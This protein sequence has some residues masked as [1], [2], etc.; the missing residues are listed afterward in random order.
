M[1]FH[2]G[3]LTV[4]TFNMRT[5][6]PEHF[7]SMAQTLRLGKFVT[8]QRIH[9][10]AIQEHH[11]YF[12]DAKAV[13]TA[14]ISTYGY[15]M[16]YTSATR[17]IIEDSCVSRGGIGLLIHDSL[18]QRAATFTIVSP[19]ILAAKLQP[20]PGLTI[21]VICVYAPTAPSMPDRTEFFSTLRRYLPT[22]PRQELRIVAGDFNSVLRASSKHPFG[23]SMPLTHDTQPAA[24]QFEAF[25]QQHDLIATS[26][27][28]DLPNKVTFFPPAGSAR[29]PLQLD[30]VLTNAENVGIIRGTRFIT[31]VPLPSDHRPTTTTFDLL[32]QMP[33]P[34]AM[35][36][37]NPPPNLRKLKSDVQA[38]NTFNET[39]ISHMQRI[40]QDCP[41]GPEHL[42]DFHDAINRA[43]A[44]LGTQ[45][46]PRALNAAKD[47]GIQQLNN[48]FDD[49]DPTDTVAQH[50]V[51]R[52]MTQLR[53]QL[54]AA[55]TKAAIDSFARYITNDPAQSYRYLRTIFRGEYC[56][57]AT[58]TAESPQHRLQLI[59][60]T[61]AAQLNNKA[62]NPFIKFDEHKEVDARKYKT[63][64]IT[65][66]ELKKAL[67]LANNNKA[68]GWDQFY[69]EFLK[70]QPVR[71]HALQ[72][73]NHCLHNGTM[74]DELK[75]T[76]FTMIPKPGAEHTKPEGY[77]Y[78]ALMPHLTKLYNIVLRERIV[79]VIDPLLRRNQ[80]GFRA[81][82]STLQ[83]IITLQS[84]MD[85]AR[86]HPEVRGLYLIFIDFKNAFPSVSHASI[87]AALRS[88]K[89]PDKLVDAIMSVYDGH[90]GYVRTPEG[91]TPKFDITAGVLQ[92]DTLAPY[93]FL[94]VLNEVLRKAIPEQADGAEPMFPGCLTTDRPRRSCAKPYKYAFSG[95]SIRDIDYADDI[96]LIELTLEAAQALL[97]AVQREAEQVGLFVNT[98]KTQFVVIKAG[99][100]VTLKKIDEDG[101]ADT[102][103]ARIARVTNYRYL[104]RLLDVNADITARVGAGWRAL[105]KLDR[106]WKA[107]QEV[108]DNNYKRRLFRTFV[109]PTMLYAMCTY[110]LTDAQTRRISGTYTRML[111]RA[112]NADHDAHLTLEQLYGWH[113]GDY[114]LELA[115]VVILRF[116]M[117][118][119]RT[120]LTDN[121]LVGYDVA[122]KFLDSGNHDTFNYTFCLASFMGTTTRTGALETSPWPP[123]A[124]RWSAQNEARWQKRT[125]E[126]AAR[127]HQALVERIKEA[128][129]ESRQRK[130]ERAPAA[131]ARQPQQEQQPARRQTSLFEFGFTSNKHGIL[132]QEQLQQPE[133]S[134]VLDAQLQQLLDAGADDELPAEAESD[135]DSDNEDDFR[136]LPSHADFL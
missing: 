73:F 90:K 10:L 128:S 68:P 83:Q 37:R 21:H 102:H 1:A 61:C 54:L 121:G 109:T 108:A 123:H 115:P 92:G 23:S 8:D 63:G 66:A 33:E 111:R 14:R 85:F 65:E 77:R 103:G 71:E 2:S 3:L 76:V 105:R 119:M 11:I 29:L 70:S 133:P 88:F 5:A 130:R 25:L 31:Q 60:D 81:K 52:Q 39:Y 7:F 112:L 106:I 131:A 110:P 122:L 16:Y 35:Q 40:L 49:I 62:Y 6:G 20:Q 93:L 18:T 15:T 38:L 116:R 89:V 74:P 27:L 4:G 113:E 50:Q 45:E 26:G 86:S 120:L 100:G 58:I 87:R 47:R 118:V 99:P 127:L 67:N 75:T 125:D 59:A 9:A 48:D 34:T 97:H 95:F 43:A 126:S 80:N 46:R 69:T 17:E 96:V 82:R 78:I 19:R 42:H 124:I 135:D 53:G 129:E 56:T 41:M 24:T 51:L 28:V 134:T 136:Y 114:G 12:P 94:L 79:P 44:T 117:S 84:V 101:M 57:R 64:P 36:R 30:Y 98:K 22:L 72:L 55:E 107:P 91:D 132:P 13:R 104:G 32:M